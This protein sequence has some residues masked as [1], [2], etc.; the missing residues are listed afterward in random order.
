M[1]GLS[2]VGGDVVLQVK[3]YR[4]FESRAFQSC[5]DTYYALDSSTLEAAVLLDAEHPGATPAALPYLTP[6]PGAASV[7]DAPGGFMRGGRG[8]SNNLTAEHLPGAW[9][10]VTGGSGPAQQLELLR[11]LHATIHL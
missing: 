3:G 11:H 8:G 10:V 9:L 5:A 4:L 2:P 7:F 6:A 1:S